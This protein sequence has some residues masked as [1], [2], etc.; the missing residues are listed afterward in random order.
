MFVFPIEHSTNLKN[1]DDKNAYFW[2]MA[3]KKCF[4][5]YVANDPCAP[6]GCSK[7]D[8]SGCDYS[9]IANPSGSNPFGL[10]GDPYSVTYSD[11]GKLTGNFDT[12][13]YVPTIDPYQ[14]QVPPKSFT[15]TLASRQ[16]VGM[17]G[18]SRFARMGGVPESI[19]QDGKTQELVTVPRFSTRNFFQ[20]GEINGVIPQ[21]W[22]NK[23]RRK[24]SWGSG[25]PLGSQLEI[26]V[27]KGADGSSTDKKSDDGMQMAKDGACVVGLAL[28][29][30]ALA[31][32]YFKR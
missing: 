17:G 13:T 28:A 18:A 30:F 10:T 16:Y 14:V 7:P 11:Q 9:G 12:R 32:L 19:T 20:D 1:L 24:T 22:D 26:G 6:W 23:Y 29:G 21:G 31:S 8:G 5:K 25:R 2:L 15:G 4:G 3:W 27:L